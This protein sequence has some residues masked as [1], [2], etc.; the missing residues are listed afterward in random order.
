MV[1]SAC[2]VQW[3]QLPG[4]AAVQGGKLHT[5]EKQQFFWLSRFFMVIFWNKSLQMEWFTWYGDLAEYAGRTGPGGRFLTRVFLQD[6]GPRGFSVFS[7]FPCEVPLW[8]W[9]QKQACR[10]WRRVL[11]QSREQ[12][13]CPPSMWSPPSIL[14]ST[15]DMC[16]FEKVPSQTDGRCICVFGFNRRKGPWDF[17]PSLKHQSSHSF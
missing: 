17:T 2:S 11:T 13:W 10:A 3:G 7:P 14:F 1:E 8:L 5:Q 16:R 4:A 6:W 9:W 15:R 12:K